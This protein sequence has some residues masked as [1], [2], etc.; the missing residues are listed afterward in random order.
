MIY[1]YNERLIEIQSFRGCLLVPGRVEVYDRG[2]V[3]VSNVCP[4]IGRSERVAFK[5]ANT[6]CIGDRRE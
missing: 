5:S 3:A 4:I 6:P 1:I 2:V